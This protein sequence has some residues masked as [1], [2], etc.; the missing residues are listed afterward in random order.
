MFFF[1][2]GGAYFGEKAQAHR[3]YCDLRNYREMYEKMLYE[4]FKEG[5]LKRYEKHI[6]PVLEKYPNIMETNDPQI[7]GKHIPLLIIL[8]S[9]QNKYMGILY[10]D[11]N[12]YGGINTV[13]VKLGTKRFFDWQDSIITNPVLNISFSCM[14]KEQ[15]K[16]SIL[17]MINSSQ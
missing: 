8:P 2:I 1:C 4:P 10:G 12:K 17:Q 16:E 9:P 3:V 5:K 15:L 11:L 7:F 14:P 6:L 13:V